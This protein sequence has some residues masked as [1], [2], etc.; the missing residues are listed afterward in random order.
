MSKKVCK[1]VKKD[2]QKEDPKAFKKMVKD[3][4]FFCK[5]CGHV[6]A[7]SCHLCKPDKL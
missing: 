2:L 6:A 4:K 3:A 5:T 7:R 1:L